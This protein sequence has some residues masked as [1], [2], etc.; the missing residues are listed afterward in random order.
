MI[1]DDRSCGEIVTQLAAVSKA[2]DRAGFKVVATGAEAVLG[3][4]RQGPDD[5]GGAR[6]ALFVARLKKSLIGGASIRRPVRTY[7]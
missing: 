1:E 5:A 3:R 2:L 6:K 4:R 7:S